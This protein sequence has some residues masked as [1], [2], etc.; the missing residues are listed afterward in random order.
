MRKT[1][2]L[3]LVAASAAALLLVAAIAKFYEAMGPNPYTAMSWLS[4]ILAFGVYA[5]MLAQ[6]TLQGRRAHLYLGAGFIALGVMCVWDALILPSSVGHLGYPSYLALWQYEW[7]T[8][9]IVLICAL[10]SDKEL[11]P[12]KYSNIGALAVTAGGIAWGILVILLTK[13]SLL[14]GLLVE[15]HIGMI[16][17]GAC[18]LCFAVAAIIYSRPS[19]HKNN[20]VLE[21]M[22]YGLFFA[23]FA[24]CALIFST[25][26]FDVFFGMSSFMRIIVVVAPLGGMLAEHTRLQFKL[27]EQSGELTNLIQAQQAISSVESSED[28]YQRIVNL[29]TV[30]LSVPA[31]CLFTFDKDRGMLSPAAGIGIDDAILRRLTFR[32]GEG[33]AGDAY[34]DKKVIYLPDVNQ[35]SVLT[36]RMEGV[37][38]V[39]SA[40]FSP[41]LA[42]NEVLGVLAVFLTGQKPSNLS[43]EQLRLLDALSGQAAIAVDGVQMRDRVSASK[44]TTEDYAGELETV[45]DIAR[46]ITSHLELNPLVDTLAEKLRTA[47][48]ATACSVMVVDPESTEPLTILGNRRLTRRHA[49]SDHSDSCDRVAF[50]VARS[51]EAQI[52]NATSNSPQC[53]YPEM[54][55]DDGGTHHMISVPMSMPG[56]EGSISVFRQNEEPFGEREKSLLMKLAPMVALGVRNAQLY[57]REKKIAE[58]LEASFL[59]DFKQAQFSGIQVDHLYK[60]AFDESLVGGDFYDIIDLGGGRYAVAIGDVSGKGLD[61]AVYTAMTRYMV[62]AFSSEDYSPAHVI[63][64]LNTALCR[65]TP[66]NKFVTIIYGIVDTAARTFSYVNAGHELPFVYRNAAG[67][68][69]TL[70]TTGPAAGALNE[71][72]YT[73]ETIDLGPQDMLVF[74]TDGAT[75][76]RSQGK[77]LGT[78]GLEKIVS[79]HIRRDAEDLTDAIYASICSWVNGRLRDDI[80]LLVIRL[81]APGSLF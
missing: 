52:L 34:S 19:V 50:N 3:I 61:A 12:R 5:V 44:R 24:E 51:G 14:S 10:L 68:L 69:E 27:Q 80:A 46:A 13:V 32:P 39:K 33:P 59:P 43:K 67:A 66:L 71:A 26:P 60:A 70:Q 36:R 73:V 31:A 11:I 42:G 79:M 57:S 48:D 16:M 76:A 47:L 1:T 2:V 35:D 28:V 63:G 37:S 56:F 9:I 64:K 78:D 81:R 23:A 75:E 72:E 6:Y 22:G 65:Y 30:S 62:R 40:V 17:A 58:S 53:K 18:G 29:V 25:S 8:L 15:G 38:G 45:S 54:A 49:V 77:F 41:L 21:W 74:Y 7:I 4:A 20:A 55:L